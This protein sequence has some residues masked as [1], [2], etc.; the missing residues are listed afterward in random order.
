MAKSQ[1]DATKEAYWRRV[2]K[3]FSASGLSVR[4]FCKREQ[5]TESAFYAWRRTIGER[6][7]TRTSGPVFVPAVVTKEAAHESSMAIELASGCVLRFSGPHAIKQLADLVI[8]LQ[9][10]RER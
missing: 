5:L 2:F 4:E 8:A 7:D 1:R 10:R 3:R 6:D 9:A